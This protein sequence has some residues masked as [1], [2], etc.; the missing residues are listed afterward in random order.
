MK[1][2]NIIFFLIL[3]SYAVGQNEDYYT[4]PLPT[5][6]GIQV[7]GSENAML[8]WVDGYS[9]ILSDNCKG[10]VVN[11]S[12]T[13]DEEGGFVYGIHH[14]QSQPFNNL[15]VDRFSILTENALNGLELFK[16]IKVVEL[17][18]GGRT[19][20]DFKLTK[21]P[22]VYIVNR[23]QIKG[24]WQLKVRWYKHLP[25]NNMTVD[26]FYFKKNEA[27]NVKILWDESIPG[28][29]TS[30]VMFGDSQLSINPNDSSTQSFGLAQSLDFSNKITSVNLGF[31]DLTDSFEE[32][33]KL[34]FQFD[35]YST[36]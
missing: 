34:E 17:K 22:G 26:K 11:P 12:G 15:T 5:C 30:A 7:V 3:S 23:K 35:F 27:I 20:G 25:G 16:G 9:D 32:D 6:S 2:L 28:R 36:W 33:D 31:F 21:K 8:N 24:F 18:S 29:H 14:L 13:V 4:N 10:I 19:V 1:L